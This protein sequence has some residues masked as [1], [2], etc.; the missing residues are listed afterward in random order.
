ML[1]PFWKD[2]DQNAALTADFYAQPGMRRE[3]LSGNGIDFSKYI[4]LLN[5]FW[6]VEEEGTQSLHNT[7]EEGEALKRLGNMSL[8]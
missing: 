4:M 3:G 6:Q 1:Q 7:D 5:I 2:A 8:M